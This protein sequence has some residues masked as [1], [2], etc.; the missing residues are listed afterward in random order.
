[1]KE[2]KHTHIAAVK[3]SV[4][5]FVFIFIFIPLITPAGIDPLVTKEPHQ[6]PAAPGPAPWKASNTHKLLGF[7]TSLS[8]AT[9]IR[10][11]RSGSLVCSTLNWIGGDV[12]SGGPGETR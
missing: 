2:N 11:R 6:E 10:D 9:A 7:L 5:H 1:M 4:F 12:S 3:E 8:S